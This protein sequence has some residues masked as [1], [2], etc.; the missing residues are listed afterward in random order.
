MTGW[1]VSGEKGAVKL[2]NIRP[3]TLEARI[4]KLGKKKN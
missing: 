3:T 1:R 2:L 4:K